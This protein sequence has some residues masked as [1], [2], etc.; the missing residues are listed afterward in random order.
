MPESDARSVVPEK[1]N[2]ARSG[3][4]DKS[5]DGVPDR[6]KAMLGVW[7]PTGVKRCS[8]CGTRQEYSD[9][10]SVVPD[11]SKAMLGVWYSARVNY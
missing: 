10:R 11:R 7:Y 3:V 4:P 8:E 2:D 5:S 1:S 9:T 6:S